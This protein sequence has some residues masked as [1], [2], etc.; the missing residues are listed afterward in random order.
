MNRF[1]AEMKLRLKKRLANWKA[2]RE[3]NNQFPPLSCHPPYVSPEEM[4]RLEQILEKRRQRRE[5]LKKQTAS[6]P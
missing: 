2:E 1:F 5:E 4:E 6:E 3:W